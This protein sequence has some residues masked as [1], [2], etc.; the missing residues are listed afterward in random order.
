MNDDEFENLQR[1]IR[2]KRHESPGEGF[3]EAFLTRFHQRQR[4]EML[5]KSSI[6]LFFERISTRFEEFMTPRWA[7]AGAA[8]LLVGFGAWAYTSQPANAP[9]MANK[10]APQPPTAK[11]GENGVLDKSKRDPNAMPAN[12]TPGD[13]TKK[14]APAIHDGSKGTLT[15]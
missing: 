1:L 3:T 15:H 10:T 8:A 12:G 6:E 14:A 13:T 4:E 7:L 2:L 5:R 11:S 9:G